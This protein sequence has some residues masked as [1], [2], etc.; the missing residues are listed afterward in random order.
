MMKRHP[1]GRWRSTKEAIVVSEASTKARWI[2]ATTIR[3]KKMG[4]SFDEIAEQ[5]TLMGRGKVHTV[6]AIPEGLAFPPDFTISRQACHKALKKA[7]SREPTL[8]AEEFR[9]LDTARSEELLMN[10]QPTIRRGNVRSI[11]TAVKV[12]DHEAKINGYAAPEKREL[13]GKDGKALTV[14]QLLEAIG[15]IDDDK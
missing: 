9:K 2:E 15:P 12:M 13:T 4:L 5:I 11:E 10:L 8:E 3:L 14:V 7:I 1:D 6:V